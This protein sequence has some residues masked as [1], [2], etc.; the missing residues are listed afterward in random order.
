MGWGKH[1][2]LLLSE[3]P[4]DYLRWMTRQ[5][6]LDPALADDVEDVLAWRRT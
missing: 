4:A 5:D 6:W 1:E 2:G 3:I